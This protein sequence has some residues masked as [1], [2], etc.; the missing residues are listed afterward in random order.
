[1]YG[2]DN[3]YSFHPPYV[4]EWNEFFARHMHFEYSKLRV[5]PERIGI[6]IEAVDHDS[7]IYGLSV[8]ALVEKLV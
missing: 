3:Y 7:F 6:I 8:P 2:S 1:L 4:P 5:E